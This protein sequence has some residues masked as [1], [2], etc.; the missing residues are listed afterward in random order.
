M[1]CHVSAPPPNA[2]SSRIAISGEM[3]RRSLTNSD[4]ALRETPSAFAPS[5]TLN[6]RGSRHS[7]WTIRPGCGGF[8]IGMVSFLLV[9][10][11][12]MHV[13]GVG[14]VKAPDHP[15]VGADG[16]RPVTS[17]VTNDGTLRRS[18]EDGKME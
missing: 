1:R 17:N 4:K 16:D 9:V 13:H 11:D 12:Q 3:P 15:P 7:C 8:F 18:R 5:V 6:P 14:S 2:L 10:V